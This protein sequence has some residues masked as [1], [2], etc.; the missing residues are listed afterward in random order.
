MGAIT[1]TANIEGT[2]TIASPI[3][4]TG[5]LIEDGDGVLTL[6]GTTPTPARPS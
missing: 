2:A 5:G 3:Q 4:G 6:S 1:L